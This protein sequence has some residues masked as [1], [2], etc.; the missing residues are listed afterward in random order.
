[1][2]ALAGTVDNPVTNTKIEGVM[3][4]IIVGFIFEF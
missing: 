2:S 1:M 4:L 3:S